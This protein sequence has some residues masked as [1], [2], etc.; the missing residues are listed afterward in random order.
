MCVCCVLCECG[1]RKA[2][3]QRCRFVWQGFRLSYYAAL[4]TEDSVKAW[5]IPF[6]P[7]VRKEQKRKAR[8]MC[9]NICVCVLTVIPVLRLPPWRPPKQSG[10]S[11]SH[12]VSSCGLSSKCLQAI[13]L[14]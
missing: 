12:R 3:C 7:L 4:P 2:C 10:G 1:E 14:A 13:L 8:T 6:A 11:A 5:Q 9:G